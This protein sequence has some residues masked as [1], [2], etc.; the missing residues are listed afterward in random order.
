MVY[1]DA[2]TSR[3]LLS[4]N[5]GFAALNLQFSLLLGGVFAII[6][7]LLTQVPR[8]DVA[9]VAF[10]VVAAGFISYTAYQEKGKGAKAF[11]LPLLHAGVQFAVLLLLSWALM[12]LDAHWLNLQARSFL[13]WLPAFAIPMT[14]IG[15]V[16]AGTI[17][18]LYLMLTCRFADMSHND[19]FSAMRLDSYRHFLRLRILGDHIT[20]FPI[21]FAKSPVRSEWRDNPDPAPPNAGTGCPSYFLPPDDFVPHLIEDPI[22]VIGHEVGTTAAI[23]KPAEMP[24]KE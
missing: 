13:I 14:L 9:I 3:T 10:A 2:D 24:P 17:F 19:A 20:V 5:W 18:G 6:G 21:G 15:G 22:T 4:G 7:Y 1:P 16:I 12:R 23:K 11:W 8:V